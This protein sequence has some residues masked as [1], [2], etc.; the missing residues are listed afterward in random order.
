MSIN[1]LPFVYNILIILIVLAILFYM[2]ELIS[3]VWLKKGILSRLTQKCVEKNL[4][5][6]H[7]IA[8]KLTQDWRGLLKPCYLYSWVATHPWRGN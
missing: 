6:G 5:Y 3:Q 1:H 7:V 4:L 8:Q 2:V